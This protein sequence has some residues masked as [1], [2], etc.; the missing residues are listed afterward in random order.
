MRKEQFFIQQHHQRTARN[1]LR[2]D[3][4]DKYKICPIA[5]KF[6]FDY[7]DGDR[8]YGYGGYKYDGRWKQIAQ[9]LIEAYNIKNGDSILEIG[10]GKGFLMFELSC[11]LPDSLIRGLDVSTYAKDN[12]KPEVK[13]HIDIGSAENLPYKDKS[14]DF[15]FSSMT[16][17]NL[18][19]PELVCALKEIDR[20]KKQDSWISVESYRNTTEKLNM[21]NWQLT[22]NSFFSY[23][24]WCWI[25]NNYYSGDY[26]FVFFT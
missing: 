22:C 3:P 2:V 5:E 7:W 24:E 14:F 21:L 9:K 8:K 15:I 12:A 26:E 18:E 1:Y 20:V 16:L 25:F 17:H 6:S 10:C 4:V 11:L 13:Q 23:K 19:L